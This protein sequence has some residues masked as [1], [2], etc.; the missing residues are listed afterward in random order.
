MSED[1]ADTAPTYDEVREEEA[2]VARAADAAEEEA[3]V[4]LAQA[5]VAEA[6]EAAIRRTLDS[7]RLRLLLLEEGE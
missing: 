6:R 1:T 3:R 5:R 7:L 4:L 2:R